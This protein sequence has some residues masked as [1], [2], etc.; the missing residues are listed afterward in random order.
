[1]PCK[2]H[3]KGFKIVCDLKKDDVAI[4]ALRCH[5]PEAYYVLGAML[6]HLQPFILMLKKK[7]AFEMKVSLPPV[8]PVSKPA[9]REGKSR[10][11]IATQRGKDRE[12]FEFA[13][14]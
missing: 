2:H 12:G 1:M 8:L 14:V 13:D 6:R 5:L 4:F 3:F 10:P 7:K 11:G 9:L